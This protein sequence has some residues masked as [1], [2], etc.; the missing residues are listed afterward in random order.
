MREGISSVDFLDSGYARG[1]EKAIWD[2][3]KQVVP[4]TAPH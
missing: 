4:I 2:T 1:M 3:P